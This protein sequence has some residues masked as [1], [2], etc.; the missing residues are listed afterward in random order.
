MYTTRHEMREG[1]WDVNND[2]WHKEINKGSRRAR[3]HLY[4][5]YEGMIQVHWRVSV[6]NIITSAINWQENMFHDNRVLQIEHQTSKV[7]VLGVDMNRDI[8]YIWPNWEYYQ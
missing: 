4:Y 8:L 3:K 6:A 7:C 2:W 1:L 5:Y